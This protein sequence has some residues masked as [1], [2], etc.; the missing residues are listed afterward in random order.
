MHHQH[1]QTPAYCYTDTPC[2]ET[3]DA[4]LSWLLT[5]FD[6]SH[7]HQRNDM[8]DSYYDIQYYKMGKRLYLIYNLCYTEGGGGYVLRSVTTPNAQANKNTCKNKAEN[9]HP[10]IELANDTGVDKRC[11]LFL[12]F[13]IGG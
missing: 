4:A 9:T 1:H 13:Q 5:P 2:M 12:C 8:R 7:V 3:N 11:G 10:A 6:P